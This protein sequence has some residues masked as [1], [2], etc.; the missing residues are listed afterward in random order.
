MTTPSLRQAVQ[1]AIAA[2]R[3]LAGE[4]ERAGQL[5][6][7][8]EEL[9]A[10]S[11]DLIA[12]IGRVTITD[13]R[14][15]ARHEE[16]LDAYADAA[17]AW[18]KV[19]GTMMALGATMVDQGHWEEVRRLADALAA[20]GESNAAVDLRTQ[21]GKALWATYDDQLRIITATMP[22]AA[23]KRS[24]ATLRAILR[25]VP[26]DFPDRNREVNRYLAPLAAAV[27]ALVKERNIEL[28]YDSRI[29]HIAAGGVARYPD[30]VTMSL[31]E[32]AAE[33]DGLT[34]DTWLG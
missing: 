5:A 11:R 26:E 23:V 25:E 32:I 9:L 21:L 29:E 4:Q 18:A 7:Q 34:G 33:F 13:D 2:Y 6:A 16:I 8:C 24:I 12:A 15:D 20:A 31:D 28:P 14:S 22:P 27:H 19:V 17:L 10:L 30:I 1:P 3:L